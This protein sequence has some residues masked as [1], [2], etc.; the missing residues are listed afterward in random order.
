MFRSRLSHRLPS[1]ATPPGTTELL[2]VVDAALRFAASGRFV[3]RADARCVLDEVRT[4]A[5]SSRAQSSVV[6]SIEAAL[7]IVT[8]ESRCER[9]RF[10]DALLDVRH[11]V[12]HVEH[13]SPRRSVAAI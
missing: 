9:G 2:R 5:E 3:S 12:S 10:L 1:P 4:T 13:D 6:A 8:Q 7:A 11:A